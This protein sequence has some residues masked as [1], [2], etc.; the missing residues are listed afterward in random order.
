MPILSDDNLYGIIEKTFIQ[1]IP[2]IL[3]HALHSKDKD[4]SYYLEKLDVTEKE[5]KI[6]RNSFSH[7]Y[8]Y[9]YIWDG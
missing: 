5:C 7:I 2:D 9:I 3:T 4:M 6:F 8:I 1:R